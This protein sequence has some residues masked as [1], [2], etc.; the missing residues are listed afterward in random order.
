MYRLP[1]YQ[2]GLWISAYID[3]RCPMCRVQPC[4]PVSTQTSGLLTQRQLLCTT[5]HTQIRWLPDVFYVDIGADD[6]LPIQAATY[7]DY[8]IRQAIAAFKQH[9]DLTRLPTLIHLLRQLPRPKGCHA[10]NSVIV[11]MPTTSA[12]L[13]K[14]GFDPVT[15]LS[16]HLSRHWRIPLWHGASR[17]DTTVSQRGLSRAERLS[18]LDN[19]FTVSSLST[20]RHLLL[21]DDVATTGASLQAL[22]CMLKDHHPRATLSAYALAH[23]SYYR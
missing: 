14:R 3:G 1:P 22:A 20:A 7:Y 16:Q 12:R 13:I 5:C 23:G 11:P 10:G 8:P 19:A 2:L 21:F 9:E 15:I 6:Y 17:I 4:A 18:N